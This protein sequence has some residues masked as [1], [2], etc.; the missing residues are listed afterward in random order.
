MN[1]VH[2]AA[3]LAAHFASDALFERLRGQ[4]ARQIDDALLR[5]LIAEHQ[6]NEVAVT[7]QLEALSAAVN[8]PRESLVARLQRRFA[9]L[10]GRIVALIAA[11]VAYD[12]RAAVQQLT[13]LSSST[14]TRDETAEQFL[15]SIFP[16]H[17]AQLLS[18]CFSEQ[19][20]DLTRTIDQLLALEVRTYHCLIWT[21]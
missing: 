9:Q 19:Q 3:I 16:Q 4:Y 7:R 15:H 20:H 8:V 12:E 17:D 18:T 2:I 14:V 21:S 1:I 13:A 10:E 6:G 11:E 5:E